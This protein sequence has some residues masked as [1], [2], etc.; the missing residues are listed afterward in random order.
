M[1]SRIRTSELVSIGSI[2]SYEDSVNP[3]RTYAVLSDANGPHA[4]FDLL[5]LEIGDSTDT[6]TSDLRQAGWKLVSA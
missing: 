1:N 3:R 5:S 4:Q 6:K 2:V